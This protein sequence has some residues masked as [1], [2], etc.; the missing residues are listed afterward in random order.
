MRQWTI[1]AFATGPF[2]G[3]PACVLEPFDVWPADAWMQ[4][5]AAE[6]NQAETAYLLKTADPDRFGLRWFTPTLEAPLCG[7]ATL[8]AAH[9]L[10]EE[11]GVDVAM[12]SF[13]TLSGVLTVRRADDQL[14]MDFPADPPRRTEIPEGLA[15]ALG[16][17]PREVW[18]GAYLVAVVD[19]ETTVRQLR[20]D[21]GAL[22]VIGG[23]ATGGAG[24]TVVVAQADA[25]ADYAVVSRFFAPGFGIPEDP[26]TGSAHCIL[27]PLFG[28][29]LGAG[30]LK[31]HQAYPG[32]GGDLE[33]ENR[34]A[35]VLLR[36]RGFT[37]M[38]SQLRLEPARN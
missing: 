6:N 35:R 36:G 25:G 31:F 20:P 34:G 17:R 30:R 33:C 13:E 21:L 37:V 32:R 12:L 38:E 14:E 18:A 28:D 24:Q 8:A 1:D 3:N 7:H 23:E 4:A 15:E 11:L 16:V 27:M 22:K 9:V 26:A 2:R 10:F 29:K 5:L 19:D